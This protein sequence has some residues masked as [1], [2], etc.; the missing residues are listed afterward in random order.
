MVH[1]R[2]AIGVVHRLLAGPPITLTLHAA[3]TWR[4]AHGERYA[5]GPAPWMERSP[6]AWSSTV[7][8]G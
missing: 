8:T 1:G 6:A 7:P 3:G 5:S 4:D 2:C